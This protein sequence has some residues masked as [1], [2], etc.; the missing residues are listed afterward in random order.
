MENYNVKLQLKASAFA[1]SPIAANPFLGEERAV[2]GRVSAKP[3]E[4]AVFNL[5]G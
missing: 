4:R 5:S 3:I 2:E 1:P